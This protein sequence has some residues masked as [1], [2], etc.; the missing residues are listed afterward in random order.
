MALI[1]IDVDLTARERSGQLQRVLHGYKRVARAMP[2]MNLVVN[3]IER[4]VPSGCIREVVVDQATA[5][6]AGGV[7]KAA[8]C[9][10]A[11]MRVGQTAALAR[12]S[13]HRDQA[14]DQIG[15]PGERREHRVT[16]RVT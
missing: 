8:G 10:G 12:R 13:I 14:A 6:T 5:T 7:Q 9:G 3:L 11:L 16:D 2:E 15:A 1:R 4:E